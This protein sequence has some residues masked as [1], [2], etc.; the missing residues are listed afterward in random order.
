MS[1]NN[2]AHTPGPWLAKK[3]GVVVGGAFHRYTNGKA[4]SQVALATMG[5]AV[6]NEA[7]RDANA[8]LIAEAGTVTTETGL[9]PRQLAEQRTKLLGERTAMAEEIAALSEQRAELLEALRTLVADFA[10]YPASDRP[11]HAFD[12]ARA[13][14]AKCGVKP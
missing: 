3:H 7:E 11:C 2:A 1:T 14:I 12:K 6:E 5:N 10:D 8:A 13:A 4:Q 9:T